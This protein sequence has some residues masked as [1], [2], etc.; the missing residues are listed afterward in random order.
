MEP[1]LRAALAEV[2]GI[3]AELPLDWLHADGD[4]SLPVQLDVERVISVRELPFTE[5]ATFW[6]LP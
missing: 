3:F 2:R 1:R 5:P 6:T 4:E